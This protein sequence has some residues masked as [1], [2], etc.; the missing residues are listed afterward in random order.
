M[1]LKKITDKV[2]Q[3]GLGLVNCFLV[4]DGDGYALVDCG[5][6]GSGPKIFEALAQL[7]KKPEHLTCLIL[8]HSHPDHAGTAAYLQQELHIPVIMHTE[9][10]ALAV[11]GIA[12]RPEGVVSPGIINWLLFRLFIA[13][14]PNAIPAFTANRIVED[15]EVIP[16]GKGIRVIHTPGHSAGHIAL[17]VG[18]ERVLLAGDICSNMGGLGLSII[19]E[20]RALGK[21][22]IRNTAA[23]YDFEIACFGHGQPLTKGAN[24]KLAAKFN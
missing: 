5:Y 24:K 4:Q 22:S 9:D 2:Y 17:L 16:I 19:Y 8:T 21:Q 14:K 18:E 13:S 3:I 7:N 1:S 23:N 20:D 10:A 11:Q 15:G 6:E 12:G